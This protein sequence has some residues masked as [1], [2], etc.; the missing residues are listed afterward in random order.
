MRLNYFDIYLQNNEYPELDG[1]IND[2][3]SL[4]ISNFTA[5]DLGS[6]QSPDMAI[7]YLS[8]NVAV[9]GPEIRVIEW[10]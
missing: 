5:Y 9:D 4:Y 8:E 2:N 3:G 7:R 10:K 6:Y 1:T